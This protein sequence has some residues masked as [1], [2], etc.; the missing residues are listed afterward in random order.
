MDK[1]LKCKE[2]NLYVCECGFFF[3]LCNGIS[4][5]VDRLVPK[6]SLYKNKLYVVWGT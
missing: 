4:T 5:F 3:F 1:R 2:N 6:L